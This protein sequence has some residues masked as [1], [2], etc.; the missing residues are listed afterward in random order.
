MVKALQKKMGKRKREE[1][2]LVNKKITGIEIVQVVVVVRV[3][4]R[5]WSIDLHTLA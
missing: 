5:T 3:L 4:A 1:V 2:W